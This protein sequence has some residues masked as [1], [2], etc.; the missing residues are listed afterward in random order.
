M[1][2]LKKLVAT[3]KAFFSAGAADDATLRGSPTTM[4]K[5]DIV[6]VQ[7]T[8]G[9]QGPYIQSAIAAIENICH[10]VSQTAH[11]PPSHIRF[12]LV[13]FR[14]HPPQA[15][16][17]VTKTFELHADM[18]V[19][20]KHLRTLSADDGGDG[21]EAVTA[22]LGKALR[23]EWKDSAAKMVVLI[24]DAPPHG[25]G[26]HDDGF[27]RSP[28]QQDPLHIARQMAEQGI[29]LFVVACE[30][31]LSCYMHAVDFYTA[32]TEITGCVVE[33]VYGQAQSI[34]KVMDNRDLKINTI[35]VD[36]IYNQSAVAQINADTWK[37]SRTIAE[38]RQKVSS[39]DGPRMQSKYLTGTK[40]PTV[41]CEKSGVSSF[42]AKRIV[43]Q[44]LMRSS[45]VTAEGMT[46]RE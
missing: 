41:K 3:L 21:P 20:Q 15:T 44:C 5:I 23:M 14:D 38:A 24:T 42:Q 25:L 9:S 19:M 11:I 32:L 13:A 17:Y 31:D 6:F 36:N 35:H 8:T 1:P 26:E 30:P 33:N 18:R 7:D 34:N 46:K 29:T 45:H 12:G 40:G 16:S 27:D 4:D 37:T 10:T 2:F 22:A 28:D 39:V 43:M